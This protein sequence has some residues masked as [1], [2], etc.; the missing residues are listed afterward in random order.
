VRAADSRRPTE[1]ARSFTG[2]PTAEQRFPSPVLPPLNSGSLHRRSQRRTAARF[3]GAPAAER[4]RR[5][6]L[7]VGR[8]NADPGASNGRS[9]RAR[10]TPEDDG[11]RPRYGIDVPSKGAPRAARRVEISEPATSPRPPSTPQSN[12]TPS[13]SGPRDGSPVIDHQ[14]D[15]EPGIGTPEHRRSGELPLPDAQGVPPRD[16]L[17]PRSSSDD[18]SEPRGTRRLVPPHCT[19]VNVACGG[20]T[21][22][23]D[24]W[25]RDNA[26]RHASRSPIGAVAP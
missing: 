5:G 26:A 15:P 4:R 10:A 6:A 20:E 23:R 17:R 22:P 11:G 9:H 16:L 14:G 25:P 24:K 8:R 13:S 18:W 1:H 19:V 7:A 3:T 21:T 2:A 12:R